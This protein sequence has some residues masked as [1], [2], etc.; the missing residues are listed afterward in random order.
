MQHRVSICDLTHSSSYL[1]SFLFEHRIL[2]ESAISCGRPFTFKEHLKLAR[3]VNRYV[4]NL[5][6][7]WYICITG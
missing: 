3:C 5:V 2:S 6:K 4:C 7:Q 1:L